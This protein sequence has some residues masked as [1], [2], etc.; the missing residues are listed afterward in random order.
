MGI[1]DV[2][3]DS[4]MSVLNCESQ[5]GGQNSLYPC[6]QPS[7]V[8]GRDEECPYVLNL[9]RYSKCDASLQAILASLPQLQQEHLE[10]DQRHHK[11]RQQDLG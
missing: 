11:S 8:A 4:D 3:D 7:R 1:I 5:T 9:V 2:T 6:I 10:C